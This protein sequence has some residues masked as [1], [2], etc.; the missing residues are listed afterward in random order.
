MVGIVCSFLVLGCVKIIEIRTTPTTEGAI[1]DLRGGVADAVVGD[2][3]VIAYQAR[4]SAGTLEVAGPQFNNE[5]IGI[6]VAKGDVALNT[7]LTDALRKIMEKK[8]YINVL[9]TWALTQAKVDPPEMMAEAPDTSTVPQLQ[10]GEL[11][12]G[13]ELSYPPMEFFDEFKNEA[14]VDVEIAKALAKE[15]GV[16]AAFVDMPF[17]ALIGAVETGKVDIALSTVTITDERSQKVDFIPYL[18]LGSGI[19][20]QKGNPKGIR[21]AKD[22]CGKIVSV[23]DATAQLSSLQAVVCE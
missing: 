16:K 3:P 12:V 9:V 10:D 11:K 2:Y 6:A 23:Q 1:G 14:G 22:L 8:A 5:T 18:T 20:V 7:V 19:L 4:E 21:N 15:L 17:D 13:M